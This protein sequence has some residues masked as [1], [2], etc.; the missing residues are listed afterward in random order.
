MCALCILSS[1]KDYR[2]TGGWIG[3]A[4]ACHGS[5][6]LTMT[7]LYVAREEARGWVEELWRDALYAPRD[8]LLSPSPKDDGRKAWL[9]VP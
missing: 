2:A 8:K 7:A 6:P 4:S 1:W 5:T 3:P 9:A